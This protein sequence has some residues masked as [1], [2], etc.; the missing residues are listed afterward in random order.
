MRKLLLLF[1]LFSVLSTINFSYCIQAQRCQCP[2][3]TIVQYGEYCPVQ[4]RVIEQR[5]FGGVSMD[6]VTR[7]F[8]AVWNYSDGES[9]QYDAE[10]ICK[11]NSKSKRCAST[12][13]SYYYSAVAISSDDKV[14]KFGNSDSYDNAWK[15]AIKNCK[16][17]G[18][19]ECEVALMASSNSEPDRKLW[20][21]LAYDPVSGMGGVS[22]NKHTQKEAFDAAIK[23]CGKEGCL[24][25]GFQSK[26]AAMAQNVGSNLK[27]GYS[28]KSMEDAEKEA[29]KEC[30]KAFK[31]KSC[32]LVIAGMSEEN[33][34]K[35]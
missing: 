4:E 11:E 13:F 12:W 31:V 27:A 33:Y 30:K 17:A 6:P 29:I 19:L 20:G 22:W 14:I 35:K 5:A 1:V 9:A 3:G 10:T 32:E 21:A 26:Y 7:E 18:G 28:N 24:A 16:I 15:E 25:V 8:G 2:D 23:V 34:F